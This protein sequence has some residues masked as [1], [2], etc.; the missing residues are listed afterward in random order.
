MSV[1]IIS[2]FIF[3][4]FIVGVLFIDLLLVGRSVHVISMKEATVWSIIWITLGLLFYFFLLH[5]SRFLH[6]ID[7]MDK[8]MEVTRKYNPYLNFKT[9]T[10]P[11]MLQE[12]QKS[13]AVSYISGYFIEKTL[14]QK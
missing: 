2:V 5:Y 11:E 7:T 13:Q 4:A 3:L 9:N 14:A 6:G 12:Y 1:E 10:F 8:L